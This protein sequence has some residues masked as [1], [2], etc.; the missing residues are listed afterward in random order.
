M[1][2][3]LP[4]L[5]AVYLSGVAGTAHALSPPVIDTEALAMGGAGV[6][7]ASDNLGNINPALVGAASRV[8]SEFYMTP[9][10]HY[11]DYNINDFS[12]KLQSFQKDPSAQ[13]LNSLNDSGIFYNWG[14]TFGIILHSHLATSTIFLSSYSQS[15]SR[16][17]LVESD[18]S[19]PGSGSEY[20]SVIETA[21]LS[22]A[23]AGVSYTSSTSWRFAN[24]GDVKWGLT[25][26]M[27]T[28]A[29][30]QSEQQVK[31]ASVDGF[32]SDG[33]TSQGLSFDVGLLKEW[34]RDWAAGVTLKNIYPVKFTLTDGGSYRYGPHAKV[35]VTRIGYRHRITLDLDL[36]KSRP[37]GIYEPTQ[38]L[39]LG[40]DYDLGGYLKL[41]AGLNYDIQDT[42]PDT[43]SVGVSINSQYFQISLALIG[44]SGTINGLGIQTTIGF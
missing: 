8:D 1:N 28:G 36:L 38:M 30:H 17:R 6:S 5:I 34:G 4:L 10:L 32:N 24:L 43:Y 16:L 37:L 31:S 9:T 19:I 11:I 26:K 39:A 7:S 35:G 13:A 18:L 22:I 23:E 21:A 41:R 20:D 15:Y 2:K 40:M 42:L 12:E 33:K 25:G 29:A 14:A 27:L 44:R 3:T